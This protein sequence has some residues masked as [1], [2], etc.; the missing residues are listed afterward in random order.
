MFNK[1]RPGPGDSLGAQE[2]LQPHPSLSFSSVLGIELRALSLLGKCSAPLKHFLSP[3]KLF[4]NGGGM[5]LPRGNFLLHLSRPRPNF[6]P[7]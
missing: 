1:L 5:A 2:G 6:L 4:S 3:L 7:L